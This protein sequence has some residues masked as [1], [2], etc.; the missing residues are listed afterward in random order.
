MN[1]ICADCL[2][3][4]IHIDEQTGEEKEICEFGYPSDLCENCLEGECDINCSHYEKYIEED[5]FVIVNCSKCG[6]ELRKAYSEDLSGEIF[7][8]NCYLYKSQ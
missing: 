2:N 4:K 3:L 6:Q 7:C 8:I 1:C 5:K